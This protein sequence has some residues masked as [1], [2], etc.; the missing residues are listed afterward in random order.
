MLCEK[1]AEIIHLLDFGLMSQSM[2][3]AQVEL[4][5]D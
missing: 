5:E 3:G 4:P 2:S 1:I